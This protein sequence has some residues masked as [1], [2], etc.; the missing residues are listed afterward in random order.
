MGRKEESKRGTENTKGAITHSPK[1]ERMRHGNP[2]HFVKGARKMAIGFL[3]VSKISRR[4]GATACARMAYV[5][6]SRVHD[7][8]IA[9][10]HDYRRKGD[11]DILASGIVGWTGSAESLAQAMS[12]AERRGDAC[13]GRSIILAVP[14][15]LSIPQSAAL[16][17]NWCHS[18]H[19]R[20][21]IA[22]AWV[23]HAPD[24]A[25]D[26]RNLHAHVIV[27]GRRSIGHALTEKARELDDRK[28][29]PAAI[30]QWRTWWG[31][32][33]ERA[34]C[35][36]GSWQRV[37]MRSWRRRLDAEGLPP[38]LIQGDEH[39]GPARSSAERRGRRTA[40]GNR[41]QR[42]RGQRK[43]AQTLVGERQALMAAGPSEHPQRESGAAAAIYV[44]RN[45]PSSVFGLKHQK[46]TKVEK[47]SGLA[48][49]TV[50]NLADEVVKNARSRDD[51]QR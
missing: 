5:L 2:R 44:K 1:G 51:D 12:L 47:V 49:R 21:G 48:S 13:E 41:N 39:L 37:D 4:T 25:G 20:H 9:A 30:E 24:K 45:P 7:P 11:E 28:T 46:R 43:V 27:T 26:K 14:H 38:D 50:D 35:Q 22:C 32:L 42:R 29:G 19:R 8:R 31:N 36:A 18:L 23:I 6:R 17:S 16:V 10:L 33:A 34:L 3:R 40:A 15:E